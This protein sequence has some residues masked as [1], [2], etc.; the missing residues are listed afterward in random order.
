MRIRKSGYVELDRT[1]YSIGKFNVVLSLYRVLEVTLYF[2]E[3]FSDIAIREL[4][5]AEVA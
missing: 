5:V 3:S 4:T 2:F 1:Y